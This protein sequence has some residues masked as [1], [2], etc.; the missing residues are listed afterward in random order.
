MDITALPY[1]P[2]VGV[3]VLN[4]DGHVFVGKRKQNLKEAFKHTWQMPQGGIDAGEDPKTAA[5]RELAEETGIT[6]DKVAVLAE[7]KTW[8]TYDLPVDL[9]PKLWGGQYRGQ[10]QKWFLL[11][12]LGR[13]SDINIKAHHPEFSAWK[14]LP[15]TELPH[16]IVPFKRD[17]Y[18]AVIAEFAGYL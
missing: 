12:F 18:R 3:M 13:D 15:P 9:I 1:R 8:I 14:W 6:A 10:T 11:R 16:A 5:L 4:A 7:T 2:N 17:V